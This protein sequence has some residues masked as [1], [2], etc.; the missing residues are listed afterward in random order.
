MVVARIEKPGWSVRATPLPE[1]SG[2]FYRLDFVMKA[3]DACGREIVLPYC[4]AVNVV[5]C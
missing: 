2:C 3:L 1:V 5:Q 4:I